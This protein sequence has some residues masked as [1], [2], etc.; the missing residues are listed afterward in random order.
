MKKTIYMMMALLLASLLSGCMKM[1]MAIDVDRDGSITSSHTILVSDPLLK[2]L[3]ISQEDFL[4]QIKENAYDANA[5]GQ[6][7]YQELSLEDQGVHY[8][9]MK[10]SNAYGD[11]LKVTTVKKKMVLEMNLDQIR[12]ILDSHQAQ[13]KA[14]K[15]DYTYERLITEGV[16][17]S[18]VITMPEVPTANIGQ[19]EG[20]QVTIDLLRL[21]MENRELPDEIFITCK[22][23]A[24]QPWLPLLLG[25]V[26]VGSI[27]GVTYQRKKQSNAGQS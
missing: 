21:I 16:E 24:S 2:K 3:N 9:G 11:A 22:K 20:K 10:M 4:A 25:A 8:T 18:I 26:V 19:I 12:K 7:D 17:L 27:A 5:Q 23:P 13:I 6:M 1:Q 14:L 15:K